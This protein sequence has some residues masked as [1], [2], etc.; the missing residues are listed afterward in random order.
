MCRIP[1]LFA[2][3]CWLPAGAVLAQSADQEVVGVVDSPDPVVPG[4]NITYVVTLSNHGPDPAGNGG[5]NVNLANGLTHVS[6]VAPAGFTCFVLGNNMT[7]NTPAFAVGTV[8]ITIVAQLEPALVN[9]ADGSV[10]SQF[11]PS[12]TTPDP[13]QAN[14]QKAAQT[15]W[16][17]P[18]IDLSMSVSDTPDP[19]GPDQLISYGARV[20]QAGPDT[21]TNVNFNTYN[22]GSLR[23]QS[24]SAPPG[25]ACAAPAAG[26]TPTFSCNAASLPPGTYD[27]T[28]VV[29]AD[30]A[31]LGINDG[32]VQTYFGANGT[33]NELTPG[34]NGETETTAYVTP[35]AD[36]S[37][38]VDDLPDPA[39]LG[40]SIEYL[41]TM[42]NAGPDAAANATINL[43]N[44]GTLRFVDAQA[45]A[46]TDCT[47]PQ[48]GAAPTLSCRVASLASGAALDLIVTVRSDPA[49]TG[50]NAV[51]VTTA[52]SATG[53]TS[54]PDPNDNAQNEDT[55]VRPSRLFRDGFEG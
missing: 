40:G 7:C 13:N 37:I 38:V 34:D 17:S 1:L 3:L 26:A 54:D 5:L 29:L 16:D 28:L 25:F 22:N 50:P 32:T 39:V 53:A 10:T 41:A 44:P 47:L 15:Q 48:P 35:D 21:A 27:F 8:Q 31:V 11:F 19:V 49:I 42:T 36:L 14:N 20:I 2:V 55:L 12:G 30:D 23:F 4:G 51:T 46:G 9:F 24:V 33:G 18:Q 6:H 45:P 52:F 43:Y